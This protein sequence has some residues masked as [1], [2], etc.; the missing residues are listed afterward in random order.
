M[1]GHGRT[2]LVKDG[3]GWSFPITGLTLQFRK[4]IGGSGGGGGL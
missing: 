2:R 3:H 4:V 1:E